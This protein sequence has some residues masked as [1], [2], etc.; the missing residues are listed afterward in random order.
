MTSSSFSRAF[1]RLPN[2]SSLY[3]LL[4]SAQHSL[5]FLLII[6]Y[7]IFS[8]FFNSSQH[9]FFCFHNLFFLSALFLFSFI[10]SSH[11]GFDLLQTL[12]F[13]AY[14]SS[15]SVMIPSSHS[16]SLYSC[17]MVHS[18]VRYILSVIRSG[19]TFSLLLSAPL[20]S[21]PVSS[22]F[23]FYLF[24]LFLSPFYFL[25]SHIFSIVP[26]HCGPP[27]PCTYLVFPMLLFHDL[28]LYSVL[29]CL[30]CSNVGLGSY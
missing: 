25:P 21:L 23:L 17:S 30:V 6:L 24:L 4:Y 27:L 29:I 3:R 19:K 28:I 22:L 5:L 1:Y 20:S 9:I 15:V 10:S 13:R 18:S 7:R 12:T 16:V 2:V 8:S 11:H 14:P 26:F